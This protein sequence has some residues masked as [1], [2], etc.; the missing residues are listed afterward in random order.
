MLYKPPSRFAVHDVVLYTRDKADAPSFFIGGL[1]YERP[2]FGD[3]THCISVSHPS[4]FRFVKRCDKLSH[5][6][7]NLSALPQFNVTNLPDHVSKRFRYF[8]KPGANLLA[9]YTIYPVA[10][11]KGNDKYYSFSFYPS[12]KGARTGK[13][14]KNTNNTYEFHRNSLCSHRT[15]KAARERAMRLVEGKGVRAER[16]KTDKQ[17]MPPNYGMCLK[18]R[19]VRPMYDITSTM[20]ENGTSTMTGK[21]EFCDTKIVKIGK[22]I[23]CSSCGDMSEA[24]MDD[25]ICKDCRS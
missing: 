4:P 1:T 16:Q 19:M 9:C 12:G 5:M 7:E 14:S 15:K 22:A 21:C 10:N 2:S 6:K 11:E 17:P 25:Y 18:E 3:Q 20:M 24:R 23:N 8:E 13:R